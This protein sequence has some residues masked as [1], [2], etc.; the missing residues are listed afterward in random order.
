MRKGGGQRIGDGLT[1]EQWTD[2][3][4]ACLWLLTAGF[5]PV[6]TFTQQSRNPPD[7]SGIAAADRGD[8]AF[9]LTPN[10]PCGPTNPS[11]MIGKVR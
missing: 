7:Q 3:W 6:T 11:D 5:P 2:H 1:H 10:T 8:S 9:K 4:A